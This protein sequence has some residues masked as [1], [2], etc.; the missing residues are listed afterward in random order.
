VDAPLGSTAPAG[1]DGGAADE[2]GAGAIG[3]RLGEA[4]AGADE[5]VARLQ[6][7]GVPAVRADGIDHLDLMLNPHMQANDLA[8]E[9]TLDDGTRFHRSSGGVEFGAQPLRIGRPEPLGAST[10]AV[11]TE[12]GYAPAAIADLHDRGVTRPVGHGLNPSP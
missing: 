9:A 8:V 6:G 5:W 4:G 12:L 7:A 11:L 10:D 1:H 2:A 3:A